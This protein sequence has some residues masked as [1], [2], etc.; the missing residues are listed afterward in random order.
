MNRPYIIRQ[1]ELL[2]EQ[3]EK[4]K[5]QMKKRN[6]EKEQ[7]LIEQKRLINIFN[8]KRRKQIIN[9][10]KEIDNEALKDD[11]EIKKKALVEND[12]K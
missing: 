1:K 10:L 12:E 8:C 4:L 11:E 2:K 6:E 5:L 7:L 3:E 9:R